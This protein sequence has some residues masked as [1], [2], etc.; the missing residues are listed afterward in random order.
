MYNLID[1]T[2]VKCALDGFGVEADADIQNPLNARTAGSRHS[3]PIDTV[4]VNGRK[5]RNSMH[6]KAHTG[7]STAYTVLTV[8]GTVKM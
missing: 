1:F 3:V 5:S 7:G 4:S 8:L 2:D 6:P